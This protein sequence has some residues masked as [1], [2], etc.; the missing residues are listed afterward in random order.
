MPGTRQ[1]KQSTKLFLKTRITSACVAFFCAFLIGGL[2]TTITSPALANDVPV[3]VGQH[4]TF[5]RIV[6]DFPRLVPYKV[7]T[8]GTSMT[9]RFTYSNGADIPD[10][11]GLQ[12]LK[13]L[14]LEKQ[15]NNELVLH[16][17]IPAQSKVKH[18]R[19]LR[20]IV[21]DI[22]ETGAKIDHDLKKIAQEV[23]E[24]EKESVKKEPEQKPK[25]EPKQPAKQTG[26]DVEAAKV[27]TVEQEPV[28]AKTP[29]KDQKAARP[30][31]IISVST[32][33]PAAMAVF[34]RNNQLWIVL[35]TPT[36]AFPPE[37]AGPLAG[38]LG[39]PE[40]LK[41][42]SGVAWRYSM[43]PDVN[44][45]VSKQNMSWQ[46]V[47]SDT[48]K[49]ALSGNRL[50]T[51][52][53][54][55]SG[56]ARLITELRS[57]GKILE[58][59]D[60]E[61]GDLLHVIPVNQI[62]QRIDRGLRAVDLEILP[63]HLGM[64][65]RQHND[66]LRVTRLGDY[67]VISTP[68]GLVMTPGTG[69]T[70]SLINE[71]D[72]AEGR[73]VRL[74]DFPNWRQG[75][76]SRLIEN[77]RIIEK[78][79]AT[80]H[81]ADDRAEGY[82]Q[83][84]LLYFANGFGPEALGA[85]RLAL[86]ENKKLDR[87]P[88]IIA[89]R[90]A[91]AAL[92]GHFNDAL[93]DLS[94]P[95]LQHQPEVK[96][97]IGYAAA[98]TEQWRKASRNFP[99]SNAL[100][101]EYPEDIAVPFTIYMA[102]SALRL[103]HTDQAKE[104]LNT[105]NS[106]SDDLEPRYRAALLYLKG[107]A[108]RQDGNFEQAIRLWEP[109]ANGIDRLY[110]A[111]ASLALT[112]LLLQEDKISLQEAIDRVDSLRFAWR[113]DGLEVA[114]LH[115]LG[116]LHIRNNAYLKGL[117][118]MRT[119]VELAQGNLDDS[120]PI[121]EDMARTFKNLYVNGMAKNIPALEAVA[122][123]NDFGELMPTGVE[124]AQAT[125]N[126]ADFLVQIDLLERAAALLEEQIENRILPN[127][128]FAEIGKRLAAIYL[129]DSRPQEAINALNKTADFKASQTIADERQLLRAR[130]FSQLNQT[131]DAIRTL[132]SLDSIA[133]QRLRADVLW[134]AR[135][136]EQAGDAIQ[137]LLPDTTPDTLTTEQAELVLNAG[138]AYK[139]GRQSAKL[140]AIKNKYHDAMLDT[141]YK[142]IFGVVTR[143]AGASDL[144]DRNTMLGIAAEVDMFKGFLDS[145]KTI[146]DSDN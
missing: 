96:L 76:I 117:N 21:V 108:H 69:A 16:A 123:F 10:I 31:T 17:T 109:V 48:L 51:E 68:D 37:L 1:H 5:T 82:M 75:G 29:I 85:L 118:T 57:T 124:G 92:A 112:D 47:L 28:S 7:D 142:D 102:E 11:N 143:E 105:L 15:E 133:A 145:Y 131:A 34:E 26:P 116:K 84:A 32:V 119:A 114:I 134:R 103:G 101:A 115:D 62:G 121:T 106:L 79:I 89:L 104:L 90:G 24:A 30:D 111:K 99:R 54:E 135:R 42:A 19:L 127:T 138:V 13:D 66:D 128:Y 45:S 60:P 52:F 98:A 70:P 23:R 27:E 113:G 122:I 9:L 64:V 65:V 77:K 38:F 72:V 50:T 22:Y 6:F 3:R 100:L 46:I 55:T 12:Q 71:E 80:A 63:A 14:R 25:P 41:F 4:N 137:N 78:Q 83:L 88:N 97:W 93:K 2:T 73:P 74:F 130:A 59:I 20:K 49:T 129:L 61:V 110:H 146:S 40:T 125:L 58:I 39:K 132:Q 136:W 18:Y 8:S 35:D 86:N 94:N 120:T 44:L 67:V 53:D 81:T 126:F 91:A 107:E 87:N 139:L 33:E 144:S 36:A 56:E 95:M 140:R 43:P 141:P